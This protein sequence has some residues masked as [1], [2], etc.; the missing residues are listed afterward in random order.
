M[1]YHINVSAESYFS[2][3]A[4]HKVVI[5]LFATLPSIVLGGLKSSV[6]VNFRVKPQNIIYFK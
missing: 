2:E 1:G 3:A 6:G 4:H 5:I